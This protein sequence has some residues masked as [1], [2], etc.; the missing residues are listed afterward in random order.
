MELSL[1]QQD[2]F[3]NVA[4]G[5]KLTEPACD[6]A[7][8]AAIWSSYEDKAFPIDW[9]FF[10]ELGLTGEVR[11]VTEAEVR[12]VEAKKLGFKTIVLPKSTPKAIL[13]KDFGVKLMTLSKIGDLASLL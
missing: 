13:D 5:L 7:A 12:I 6:L 10:G 9:V 8:A 3:F 11:R 4:G 2:L 1:A